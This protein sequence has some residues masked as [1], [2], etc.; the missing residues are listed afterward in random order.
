V[1]EFILAGRP[2]SIVLTPETTYL[3]GLCGQICSSV[4]DQASHIKQDHPEF[5]NKAC[6][7]TGIW[8]DPRSIIEKFAAHDEIIESDPISLLWR[9]QKHVA[10]TRIAVKFKTRAFYVDPELEEFF[11][12]SLKEL[13]GQTHRYPFATELYKD[14]ARGLMLI[15]GWVA[16]PNFAR[17]SFRYSADYWMRA[18]ELQ[19]ANGHS[20]FS[21][22]DR[23]SMKKVMLQLNDADN[24]SSAAGFPNAPLFLPLKRKM[25]KINT[26]NAEWPQ[27]IDLLELIEN[28]TTRE[29][30]RPFFR[31]ILARLQY[32]KTQQQQIFK[33]VL[34]GE[35]DEDDINWNIVDALDNELLELAE[36]LSFCADLPS[37]DRSY[38]KGHIE[39]FYAHRMAR[40]SKIDEGLAIAERAFKTLSTYESDHP[41]GTLLQEELIEQYAPNQHYTALEALLTT[42]GL[43][44]QSDQNQEAEHAYQE[45]ITFAEKYT[46]LA[47]NRYL[48]AIIKT[49]EHHQQL[50]D[51]K[52][53]THLDTAITFI[54]NISGDLAESIANED[55]TL[56]NLLERKVALLELFG[57]ADEAE[58]LSKELEAFSESPLVQ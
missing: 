22:I 15:P 36:Q 20:A 44:S 34:Y 52:A 19:I 24:A 16:G 50:F 35:V 53:L 8:R 26:F 49:V 56:L 1:N 57:Q 46:E 32:I 5:F 6:E 30:I 42:A 39:L 23:I 18:A 38:W 4:D 17:S 48:T 55:T 12:H 11:I 54:T 21:K 33:M 3:C 43:Y 40:K 41:E 9:L 29:T 14:I 2:M 45:A 28:G 47:P 13:E 37:S 25:F 7:R 51:D 31:D 58:S 10:A 27:R